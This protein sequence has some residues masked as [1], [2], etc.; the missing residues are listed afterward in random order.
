MKLSDDK[1]PDQFVKALYDFEAHIMLE[2]RL[3]AN[4]VKSYISDLT[5]FFEYLNKKGIDSPMEIS[6]RDANDY[7]SE[8][9]LKPKSKARIG[10]SIRAFL[11]FLTTYSDAPVADPEDV[12]LPKTPKNLP[13]VLT[14]EEV[15]RLISTASSES[16]YD[17]RDR[18]VIETLYATGMRVSELVN[19]TVER[20][21]FQERL[22]RVVGKGS[23][24]R[25]VPF[26]KS[27]E[28]SLRKWMGLRRGLLLSKGA[29]SPYVFLSKNLKKMT[30][31]AVFRILKKRAKMAGIRSI[32]PHSLRHSCATHMIENG[33]DLRAVQEI[34]GHASL[35]TTEIY[36]HVSRD[37]IRRIFEEYH[38]W[39]R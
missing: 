31:D 38:P 35:S 15:E 29:V 21:D 37:F 22:I 14:I 4:T 24:E 17:I 27:A 8:L 32:S 20:I 16:F 2:R 9:N 18:A 25:I 39:G 34:L 5:A 30:R 10:S 12:V 33:A 6:S 11:K 7:I 36:T 3:S 28:E 13:D 23:K 19:L 1:L 26:G